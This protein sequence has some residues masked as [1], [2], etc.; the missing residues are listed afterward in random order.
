MAL[1]ISGLLMTFLISP[2]VNVASVNKQV[3]TGEWLEHYRSDMIKALRDQAAWES[4]VQYNANLTCIRDKTDCS[5]LQGSAHPI[6]V[7]EIQPSGSTRLLS[8]T[9]SSSSGL[10]VNGRPCN[11]FNAVSGSDQCPFRIEASWV[12]LCQAD[13]F[14]PEVRIR[15]N[16]IYR[17]SEANANRMVLN[18]DRYT[19][20]LYRLPFAETAEST[21]IAQGG[22]YV[23]GVCII[24]PRAPCP[25]GTAVSG[26]TSDNTRICRPPHGT[27][28]CPDGTYL[29]GVDAEGNPICGRCI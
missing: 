24:D 7:W 6:R 13:C 22:A 18:M 25:D 15:V 2:L 27:F 17:P 29:N 12:P 14:S 16:F 3:T 20:R 19:F 21:C 4:M 9:D 5:Q 1:A 23:N 28:R 8:T 26:F 11:S 10:D